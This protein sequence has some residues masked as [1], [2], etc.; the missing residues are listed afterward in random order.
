[1][2]SSKFIS[3]QNITQSNLFSIIKT[4]DEEEI[5]IPLE[6][7]VLEKENINQYVVYG[8]IQTL[9]NKFISKKFYYS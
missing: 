1:M 5:F 4:I 7:K 3:Q 2:L 6:M 8:E 9:N